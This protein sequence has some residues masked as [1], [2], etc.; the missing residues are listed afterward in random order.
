MFIEDANERLVAEQAVLAFRAVKHA[1]QEAV[2]GRGMLAMEEA[3]LAHG[4]EH[5]CRMLELAASAH[6]E[7]QKG[8]PAHGGV[9]AR[10]RRCTKWGQATPASPSRTRD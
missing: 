4:H 7:A 6:D 5:L 9:S 1:A 2:H 10:A 8:G 3:I